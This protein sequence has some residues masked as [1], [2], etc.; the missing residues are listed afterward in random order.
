MARAVH[1]GL[2]LRNA[3]AGPRATLQLQE[4]GRKGGFITP[5]D[6]NSAK[7]ATGVGDLLT[8]ELTFVSAGGHGRTARAACADLT[9][10]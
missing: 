6:H 3:R 8:G 4:T 7:A 5:P 10:K 2:T 9:V 1:A